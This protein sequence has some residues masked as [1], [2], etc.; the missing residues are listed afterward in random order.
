MTP[1]I[2]PLRIRVRLFAMQREAA[3]MR[4]LRLEVPLGSTV[5]DA[6]NAVVAT[7][8]SLAPGR[9]SLRFAVNGEYA[10]DDLTLADGDELACIPPVSGGA[11]ADEARTARADGSCAS[12]RSR[13]RAT[14]ARGWPRS[15]PRTRT[16]AS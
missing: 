9:A 15:S 5:D 3:G 1:P 12:R 11:G 2:P 13:C 7:M 4:E 6:W 8:P 14:S 16:A 10:D